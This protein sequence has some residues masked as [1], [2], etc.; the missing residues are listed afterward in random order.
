MPTARDV[1]KLAG[2]SNAVVSYVFNNGPRAVSADARE[3]VL[4]AARELD[5]KPNALARAL[6]AGKTRSIGLIVPDIANPFF[7]EL[8]RAVEVAAAARDHL[9]LI[10]DSATVAEHERRHIESFIERQVDSLILISLLDEP[11]LKAAHLA[12]LPV[13]ALHP[14][15][16]GQLASSLT[17]DYEH[18]AYIATHHLLEQGYASIGLLNGPVD[19]VGTRQHAAGFARAVAGSAVRV[20]ERSSA[21]SRAAAAEASIEWLRSP[22]APRAIYAT[23]DEQGQGVLFAAYSLGLRVPEDVAVVSVD[24]TEAG[25]YSVPPL[26]SISQPTQAIARRAVEI[27]V[28]R[29]ADDP[30]VNEIFNFELIVRKSSKA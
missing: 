5:Y 19:S 21:I 18:A 24:G 30:I 22:D 17:I 16:E 13:V 23:T 14:L 27:L 12:R 7:A 4:R 6:S 26:S 15:S 10:G 28:D 3:R 2:T 1:A 29:T 11:D 8:A 25:A 20:A 9:L